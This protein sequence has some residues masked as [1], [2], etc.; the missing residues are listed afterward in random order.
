MSNFYFIQTENDDTIIEFVRRPLAGTEL[1]VENDTVEEAVA[2]VCQRLERYTLLPGL[3]PHVYESPIGKD[4]EPMRGYTQFFGNF[5]GISAAFTITTRDVLTIARL[6][7][8]INTN[9]ESP[10]YKT[11]QRAWRIERDRKAEARR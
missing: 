11:A 10:E 9:H 3:S 5:E 8:A 4:G 2:L 7:T 6:T 1:A